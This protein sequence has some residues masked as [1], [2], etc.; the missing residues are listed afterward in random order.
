MK[1]R[2]P[3]FLLTL[4]V[5]GATFQAQAQTSITAVD[6]TPQTGD[7]FKLKM[8]NYVAPGNGGANQTWNFGSMLATANATNDYVTRAAA[9]FPTS[10]PAATIVSKTSQNEYQYL[11]TLPNMIRTHAA[12]SGAQNLMITYSNPVDISFPMN[13][14]V[15]TADAY[16]ATFTTGGMNFIRKG[17]M[18]ITYDGY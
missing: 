2:L 1:K 6:Y 5:A 8:A 4:L 14:N 13:Y 11:E 7:H 10:V 15:P 16:Q 9:P 3:S 17:T 12:Y 18:T